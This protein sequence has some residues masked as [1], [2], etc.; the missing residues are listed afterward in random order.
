MQAHYNDFFTKRVT[1]YMNINV[2]IYN[3]LF[4]CIL[5][6]FL[7]Q[8]STEWITLEP[9]APWNNISY[10]C[11]WPVDWKCTIDIAMPFNIRTFQCPEAK[12]KTFSIT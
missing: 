2:Y 8:S 11:D 6:L 10:A 5:S 1:I 7:K 9:F 12:I 4:L 3:G